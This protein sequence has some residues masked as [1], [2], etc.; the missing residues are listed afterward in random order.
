MITSALSWS[1]GIIVSHWTFAFPTLF[2]FSIWCHTSFIFLV[3]L[4]MSLGA[5]SWLRM[6]FSLSV[7]WS[8]LWIVF[9]NLKAFWAWF[10]LALRLAF[11]LSFDG[12]LTRFNLGW[13]LRSRILASIITFC[14][15]M[16]ATFLSRHAGYNWGWLL[17]L[18]SFVSC[19]S[20]LWI[21][22]WPMLRLSHLWVIFHF[23]CCWDF[24]N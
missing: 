11:V 12:D 2:H 24:Q 15:F 21:T 5:T 4:F 22:S 19:M 20:R 18:V 16:V 10:V 14:D 3:V 6:V 23:C 17:A 13:W 8:A 9:F 1:L 7:T